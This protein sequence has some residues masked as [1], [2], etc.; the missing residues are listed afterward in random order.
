MTSET[1]RSIDVTLGNAA[2]IEEQWAREAGEFSERH[3]LLRGKAP[4]TP[5]DDA[6][7][8]AFRDEWPRLAID[9]LDVNIMKGEEKLKWQAFLEERIK[10]L[11][12]DDWSFGTLLRVDHRR[13][14]EA[15][16]CVLV[17][18]GQF[19]CIE[20]ARQREFGYE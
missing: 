12:P 16:N 8:R 1:E 5:V 6:L 10:D 14:Y 20:I 18:R 7:L 11:V 19:Y 17:P 15:D 13:G 9:V 2:N 4:F 3:W